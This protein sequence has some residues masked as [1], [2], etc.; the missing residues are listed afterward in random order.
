MPQT[1]TKAGGTSVLKTITF[2]QLIATV[3]SLCKKMVRTGTS[4]TVG[5]S[6]QPVFIDN[7]VAKAVTSVPESL[8]TWGGRNY[9][10]GWGL[11]DAAMVDNFRADRLRF[12]PG[13][14]VDVEYSRDGGTTWV[15]YEATDAAKARIFDG[16]GD[17]SFVIG[18][19]TA[20]TTPS[21]DMMLRVTMNTAGASLY[22]SLRKFVICVTTNGSNACWC[23][24][25]LRLQKNV[26]EGT[27]TWLNVANHVPIAGWSGYNVI[28]LPSSYLTYGNT[29]TSQYGQ[30][31]FTFGNL[32]PNTTTTY[33]GLTLWGIQGFSTSVHNSPSSM[34]RHGHLY[35]WNS[36]KDATFPAAVSAASLDAPKF[37]RSASSITIQTTANY[38]IN[39]RRNADANAIYLGAGVFGPY[40]ASAEKLDL[41][42]SISRWKKL[43]VQDIDVSGT[44]NMNNVTAASLYSMG[45]IIAEGALTVDGGAELEGNVFCAGDMY[46]LSV[47]GGG[48]GNLTVEGDGSFDQDLTVSGTVRPGCIS[49]EASGAAQQYSARVQKNNK[50]PDLQLLH[51]ARANWNN[52]GDE[53]PLEIKYNGDRYT[54]ISM[55][56][57]GVYV[58]SAAEGGGVAF[59][60][61]TKKTDTEDGELFGVFGNGDAAALGSM[62][63]T[64]FNQSSDVRLKDVKGDVTLTAD[65]VAAAPMIAFGWNERARADH[66]A[67]VGTTAQYWHKVLPDVV[68]AD[69]RGYW[70]LDYA[71][72]AMLSTIATAREVVAL[73]REVAELKAE[74]KRMR[75]ACSD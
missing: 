12:F 1:E 15:D 71:T 61:G 9:S 35:T 42:R 55:D 39:F 14:K 45:N 8:L 59:G 40:K 20:G 23:S 66:D 74:L 19:N 50:A 67:H 11:L 44:L 48:G 65:D 3:K 70:T 28:N 54:G 73:R 4:T 37:Q 60:V 24:I 64:A 18:K 30:V 63:A 69:R 2:G 47:G 10:A 38:D 27:D 17:A 29:K 56:S 7:G 58:C 49:F 16:L 31:R 13:S 6:T 46:V 57:K 62:T 32:G 75:E 52:T 68:R 5:S 34:A 41:G 33:P 72:A 43:W 53:A 22:A 36:A 25:D 26:E 51:Q 21:P